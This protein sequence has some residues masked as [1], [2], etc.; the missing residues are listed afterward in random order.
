MLTASRRNPYA[1]GPT[2]NAA[3]FDLSYV[4]S[5]IRS[6]TSLGAHFPPSQVLFRFQ[7]QQAPVQVVEKERTVEVML[8]V[9][10]MIRCLGLSKWQRCARHAKGILVNRPL[11]C[12]M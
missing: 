8:F 4:L 9:T 6:A 12:C 3:P 10:G 7:Q 11:W 1:L 5:G 2:R